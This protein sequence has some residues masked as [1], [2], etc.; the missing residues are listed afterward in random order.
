MPDVTG[1]ED[2]LVVGERCVVVEV[3][4]RIG[5][6]GGAKAEKPCD[7]PLF[8]VF[9]ARVDVHREVEQVRDHQRRPRLQ[10]V[11]P[12]EDEDVRVADNLLLAENDVVEQMRIHR[13]AD[14]I[15]S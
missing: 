8:D 12:L 3:G 6:R 13:R 10:H 5:E 4:R 15:G 9:D 14:L 11:Q 2:R 7:V 1:S